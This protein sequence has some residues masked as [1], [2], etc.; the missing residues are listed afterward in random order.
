VAKL[1]YASNMSLDGCTE[2]ARGA[3]DWAPPDDDVFVFITGIMRSAGTYLYGRRMYETM[4]V[5]ETDAA[6][7]AQT[8][9]MREFAN[10]WCAADKVVYSTTLAAPP[11]AKT[12]LERHFDP[13]AVR[14]L[15]RAARRDVLVGGPHL[16]AHAF[17][18]GL[19]DECQLLIWPV[20]LGGGNPAL[21][22][23]VRAELVL[24]DEH[25]FSNGVVH[26]RYRVS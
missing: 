9:L 18:A 13:G 22:T 10:V 2:D 1:I 3:F 11:T 16:A 24:L 20:I 5:W 17:R 8:D 19:V 14:D 23:D 4:A 21:P 26:L 15:K 6:L 7:A 12:R 25:R